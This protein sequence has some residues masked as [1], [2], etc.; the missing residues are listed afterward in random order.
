[1]FLNI[2]IEPHAKPFINTVT[3]PAEEIKYWTMSPD[4]NI[5]GISTFYWIPIEQKGLGS[6]AEP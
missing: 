1:M 6:V 3:I 4:V 2:K 5:F